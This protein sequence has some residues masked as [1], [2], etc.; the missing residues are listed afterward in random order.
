ML[1]KTETEEVLTNG[2]KMMTKA[3]DALTKQNEILNRDIEELK[4]KASRLQERVLEN[5]EERE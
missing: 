4:N 1:F 5:D 2:L 3:C